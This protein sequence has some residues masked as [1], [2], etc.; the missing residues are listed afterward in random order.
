MAGNSNT[1]EIKLRFLTE[2]LDAIQG[3][4]KELEGLKRSAL[5]TTSA[6]K[7]LVTIGALKVALSEVTAAFAEVKRAIDLGGELPWAFYSMLP[8][9]VLSPQWNPGDVVQ[10]PFVGYS[11]KRCASYAGLDLDAA[12]VPRLL[13]KCLHSLQSSQILRKN[14]ING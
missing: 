13:N 11:V 4:V 2:K 3:S 6:L 14:L 7:G 5:S 1:I 9:W 8:G 12:A 10:H